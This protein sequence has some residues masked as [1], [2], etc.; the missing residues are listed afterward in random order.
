M[1]ERKMVTLNITGMTCVACSNRIEKVLNKMDGVEANVNLAMEKATVQ[2]DPAKQSIVD[3]QAKIE[4]LGYGVA[5]EKVTL[6]IE[7][8]TCAACA[9]GIEKGLARMEGGQR[10]N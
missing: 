4:H 10:V 8:M 2:Y 7:S 6:D 9:A 5:T 3:I 1:G